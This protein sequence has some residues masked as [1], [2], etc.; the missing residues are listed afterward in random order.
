MVKRVRLLWAVFALEFVK[1]SLHP[2][3]RVGRT[4]GHEWQLDTHPHRHEN[5]YTTVLRLR[6]GVILNNDP[7]VQ[8]NSRL[9]APKFER[10]LRKQ[11]QQGGDEVAALLTGNGAG[12]DWTTGKFDEDRLK[13]V[14]ESNEPSTI[15]QQRVEEELRKM[16]Q[17]DTNIHTGDKGGAEDEL[18]TTMRADRSQADA[19]ASYGLYD[20]ETAEKCFNYEELLP[21]LEEVNELFRQVRWAAA[22]AVSSGGQNGSRHIVEDSAWLLAWTAC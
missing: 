2:C 17:M 4:E 19:C 12:Q 8:C 18:F 9:R 1:T 21:H 10:A 14:L 7:D 16:P 6:G 15:M 22:L 5:A 13:R 3:A 11:T 20:D